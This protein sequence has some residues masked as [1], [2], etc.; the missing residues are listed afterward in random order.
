PDIVIFLSLDSSVSL[1]SVQRGQGTSPASLHHPL[2]LPLH[3]HTTS[4]LKSNY[5]CGIGLS[6][7]HTQNKSSNKSDGNFAL[8][9]N[10]PFRRPVPENP[11]RRLFGL[12]CDNVPGGLVISGSYWKPM[13]PG[14]P[15][16]R[17][18]VYLSET[19]RW[20]GEDGWGLASVEAAGGAP[21]Y[22]AGTGVCWTVDVF[23]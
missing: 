17:K 13:F 16:P 10:S 15:T 2:P 4:A 6:I 7:A 1:L 18:S 11:R 5:P 22:S 19:V 23:E 21:R 14:S 9:A 8:L 12:V 3:H 20:P